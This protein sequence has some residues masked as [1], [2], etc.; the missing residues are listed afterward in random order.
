MN[1]FQILIWLL[2]GSL[3]AQPS[4]SVGEALE[5]ARQTHPALQGTAGRIAAAR[6]GIAQ[7]RLS[8]NPKLFVQTE[9]WRGWNTPG[10]SSS[11]V[12][13]YAYLSQPVELGGK[14]QRRSA[15]AESSLLRVELERELVE[16]QVLVAVKQAYWGA[17]G[18]ERVHRVLLQSLENFQQ[19]IDYHEAR[20]REGAMAEADLL[21]VRLEGERLALALNTSALEA[22]RSRIQLFR[23][24]GQVSFP[25][26]QLTD[27][28]ETPVGAPVADMEAALA[29][30]LE[31]KIAQAAKDEAAANL[32]LQQALATPDADLVFGYKQTSGYPTVIGGVQWNLPFRNRNQGN[33]ASADASIRI[34]DS[35]IAATAA[36]IR[37]EVKA[38]DLEVQMRRKQ[39]TGT[40]PK[41]LEQAAESA[42]IA[43]AAYREG[44]TDLL[45][46]LD[47]QR[48]RIDLE[49]LYSRALA[50]YRQSVTAME[51]AMGVNP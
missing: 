36:Q 11:Q 8:P 10:L 5:K 51:A 20:V 27:T 29:S 30:R 46:L 31:I 7:A 34:A 44:G 39:V 40:L 41:L 12:D 15:L 2:A 17:A 43:L 38:A 18:A 28:L 47:A 33:I 1:R 48:V 3:H 4:M 32:R 35:D 23:A 37:A 26:V 25:E 22:E 6:A 50:E 16:R 42:R 49:A 13:T 14:R 19:V 9:N 21:K 45:R 24:M